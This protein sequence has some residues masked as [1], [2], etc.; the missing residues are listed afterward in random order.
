MNEEEFDKKWTPIYKGHVNH[1][2]DEPSP[3]TRERLKALEVTQNNIMDYLKENK[4]EHKE[5]FNIVEDI[6]KKLDNALVGKADKSEVAILKETVDGLKEWKVKIAVIGS[7]LLFIL[8]FFK[9]A[10]LSLIKHL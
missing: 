10:I 1:L 8:T 4:E 7:V 9:D 2:H 6:D 5:L 3:E